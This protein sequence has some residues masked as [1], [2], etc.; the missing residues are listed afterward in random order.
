[1][2]WTPDTHNISFEIEDGRVIS[3]KSSDDKYIGRD[4]QEVYDEVVSEHIAI[5]ESGRKE[6]LERGEITLA[7]LLE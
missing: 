5:N 2:K 4:V 3:F 6:E 1:M 7:S